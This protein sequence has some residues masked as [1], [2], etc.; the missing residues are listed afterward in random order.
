MKTESSAL[1]D[2]VSSQSLPN[3][4]D[5]IF[6]AIYD[7]KNEQFLLQENVL[8]D[9]KENFPSA[10]DSDYRSGLLK[11]FISL[12]NTYGGIAVFGVRNE[13]FRPVGVHGQFDIEKYNA[14]LTD[15]FGVQIELIRKSYSVMVSGERTNTSTCVFSAK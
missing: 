4:F 6:G 15:L 12:Y 8:L 2:A 14:L 5:K 3:E 13:D 9:Y 10:S 7:L 1:I 11:L